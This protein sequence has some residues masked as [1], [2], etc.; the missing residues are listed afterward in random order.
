MPKSG[1]LHGWYWTLPV[2]TALLWF[3]D[4]VTMLGLWAHQGHRRY[5]NKEPMPPYISDVGAANHHTFE[6]LSIA[7]AAMY[8][9][10]ILTERYLRHR[11]RIPGSITRRAT[12]FD[13]L[14]VFFTWIGCLGLIFLSIFDAFDYSTVRT[15]RSPKTWRCFDAD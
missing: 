5:K 13:I 12:H 11:R 9:I 7:T 10:T 6:A 2:V 4:L 1:P 15:Y 8:M 3:A 14:C